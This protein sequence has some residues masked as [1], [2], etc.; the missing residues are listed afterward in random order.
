MFLLILMPGCRQTNPYNIQDD[1]FAV[2]TAPLSLNKE[3]NTTYIPHGSII[4]HWA[5]GITEVYGLDNNRL[6]IARDSD[7]AQVSAPGGPSPAT[8]IREVPN[9][10]RISEDNGI[11]RIYLGDTLIL[12]VIHKTENFY[13]NV[14][15]S[16]E[17]KITAKGVH[18]NWGEDI[19]FHGYSV[20]PDGTYLQT[21]LYADDKPQ[22][23]W[24]V[25][26]YIQVR[27]GKWQITVPLNELSESITKLYIG[28]ETIFLFKVWEKDNP[29]VTDTY[30]FDLKGPPPIPEP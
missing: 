20:L 14:P 25:D 18:I 3:A 17:E 23:W 27:D 21:Q 2:I 5:D 19:S 22:V 24:P 29:L 10:S 8:H 15:V 9:Q 4:Y 28:S 13:S 12:T 7:A 11:T 6:F 30:G 26:K 16:G 1:G